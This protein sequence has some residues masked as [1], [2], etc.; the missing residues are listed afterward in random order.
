M[1]ITV[2]RFARSLVR[3][4]MARLALCDHG[5]YLTIFP[6]RV[7]QPATWNEDDEAFDDARITLAHLV[8]TAIDQAGYAIEEGEAGA[9]NDLRQLYRLLHA[10]DL[11]E[12]DCGVPIM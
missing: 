11:D 1:N 7:E 6:D 12:L 5:P 9:R 2:H 8:G 4:Q 10:V 3:S